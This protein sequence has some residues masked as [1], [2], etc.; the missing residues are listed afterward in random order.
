MYKGPEARGAVSMGR[1]ERGQVA[2]EEGRVGQQGKPWQGFLGHRS[3]WALFLGEA[4]GDRSERQ[5]GLEDL[6]GGECLRLW[7][8]M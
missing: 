2:G 3:S 5:R 6:A 8:R 7:N 1:T 4:S